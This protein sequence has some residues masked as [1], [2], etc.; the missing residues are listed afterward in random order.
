MKG[1]DKMIVF[2]WDGKIIID[3]KV[4]PKTKGNEVI[5]AINEFKH[6]YKVPNSNIAF[7]NDGVGSFVDG[8][9]KGSQEFNNGSKALNDENYFNLKTQCFYKSGE[10]VYD[11]EYYI[12]EHVANRMY[13]EKMTLR[14]RLIYERR[15]VKRDKADYDGKLKI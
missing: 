12:P 11:G 2:V 15:A 10:S 13:D 4:L 8:F 1:S 14:Q 3:F 9:I 5:D 7:D 6:K